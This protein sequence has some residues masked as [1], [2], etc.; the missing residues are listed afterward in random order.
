MGT[1]KKMK[2]KK[3]IKTAVATETHTCVRNWIKVKGKYISP[4]AQA[5][6]GSCLTKWP[7]LGDIFG[8]L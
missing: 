8:Y 5:L 4:G 1:V 3:N 7:T 2:L 6:F